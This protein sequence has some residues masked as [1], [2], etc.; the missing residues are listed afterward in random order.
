MNELDHIGF[1]HMKM[2]SEVINK[3]KQHTGHA[4]VEIKLHDPSFLIKFKGV[5]IY[6]SGSMAATI[7]LSQ[8]PYIVM[9]EK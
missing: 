7:S 2:L 3:I 9:D 5:N 1:N 4:P 6:C 8:T